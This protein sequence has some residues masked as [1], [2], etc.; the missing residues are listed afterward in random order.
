M[1]RYHEDAD[2]VGSDL[3]MAALEEGRRRTK[4]VAL[5]ASRA[6]ALAQCAQVAEL[7]A[8]RSGDARFH[9]AAHVEQYIKFLCELVEELNNRKGV[10][11][12]LEDEGL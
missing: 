1:S 4:R 2:E 9:R 6:C 12:W 8:I 11:A 7:I 10:L 5:S 3:E